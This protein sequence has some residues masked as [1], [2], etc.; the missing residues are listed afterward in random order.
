M[1]K[2]CIGLLCLGIITTGV[3]L[4]G[5]TVK[6]NKQTINY[7]RKLQ[8]YLPS[9]TTGQRPTG[10]IDLSEGPKARYDAKLGPHDLNFDIKISNPYKYE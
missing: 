4:S 7:Q 9:G 1:K 2:T 5:C 10:M 6:S 8:N 3:L